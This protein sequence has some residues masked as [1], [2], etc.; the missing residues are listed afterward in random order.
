MVHPN[1]ERT[2]V[3][4]NTLVCKQY[5]FFFTV[6]NSSSIL[7]SSF[8]NSS[9]SISLRFYG[10]TVS[11]VSADVKSAPVKSAKLKSAYR[12][13]EWDMSALLKQV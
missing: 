9:F 8:A 11:V 4:R 10:N 12:R 1:F 2:D 13:L 7:N 5:R 3:F 6:E